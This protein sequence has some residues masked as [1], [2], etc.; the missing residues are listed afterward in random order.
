MDKFIRS[1]CF[2]VAMGMVVLVFP[3]GL[4]A[5]FLTVVLAAGF[6]L[7]F[8]KYTDEKGF[9][10]NVF[11]IAL[12]ARLAFGIFVNFYDL[13]GF[14]GGDSNTYDAFGA[15]LSEYWFGLASADDPVVR[16]AASTT[17]SGWGM[18]HLVAVLYSV[19]GRNI[20]LAQSFCGVIGA[21]TAPLV[22]FCA[23]QIFQNSRVAK[24][25]ALSVALFPAFIIWSGMLLKDGLIVFLLV[26]TMTMVLQLQQRFNYAAV[27]LL[28]A[29]LLGIMSLRFYIF[30]MVALAV[31]GSFLVGVSNSAQSIVRRTAALVV[32]GLGLTYFGVMRSASV[33]YERYGSLQRIQASRLNLATAA[34][35]GFGEDVDVSTT[36]GALTAIP[37]GLAYLM[38]APFPWD[39][40]N[41]R[42]AIT[43]PEVFLWWALIPLMAYG[44][45][46]TVR[47]KLRTA[48]PIVI[49]SLMLTLAYSIYQ[50]NVGTA[51]RQRTQIQVFLFMFIAVGWALYKERKADQ[52]AIR[53]MR[54]RKTASAMHA[55]YQ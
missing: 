9:V 36:S 51:Y 7:I 3:D 29:S 1:I 54:Q 52:Q 33:D 44:F 39:V 41:F 22:Y 28:V 8:R 42:Q 21:A 45:W 30:Y 43:L 38:L 10:T 12:A 11:L 32:I 16:W 31:V 15:R 35:S 48:F 53:I 27:V 13:R 19:F 55:G 49:F 34:E 25:S 2:L 40:K 20:F 6:L 47:H 14:F 24:V 23:R 18:N 46:Y 17:G 26:L 5:L 37:L 4:T 50:G